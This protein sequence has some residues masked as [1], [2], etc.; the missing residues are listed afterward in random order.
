MWPLPPARTLLW[1][2]VL[3]AIVS[4]AFG[5]NLFAGL[6]GLGRQFGLDLNQFGMMGN[7]RQQQQQPQMQQMQQ[8]PLGQML[9][10]M[11]LGQLAQGLQQTING[12]AASFFAPPPA[13]Q[14]G[15]PPHV[16]RRVMRFCT[17]KPDHPK[18]RGHPEWV[19]RNG[20]LPPPAQAGG[21]DLSNLQDAFP[22]L[23]GNFQLPPVPMMA[24]QNV[25]ANVPDVLKAFVPA[26]IL[27]QITAF[28]KQALLKPEAL[29]QRA[30][31][32]EHEA[33]V[34]KV[35]SPHK[36][37]D[38]IDH[39]VE[40]RLAR[41]HQVKK[42]LLKKA[43]LDATVEPE[44][45]G[46]F[47]KDIL[48]TEGQANLLINEINSNRVAPAPPGA[49][50]ARGRARAA[51]RRHKRNAVFLEQNAAQMW[52]AGQPIPYMFDQS[53]SEVDKGAVHEAVRQIQTAVPCIRFQFV[54]S[55]P[56]TS[57]LYYTKIAS[58]TL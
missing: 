43:G 17:R 51:A 41:T 2:S 1:S 37:I 25:L 57:H 55:K 33:V 34:R 23:L 10:G 27:G 14:S 13:S 58:P 50:R 47:Q 38:Q 52:P 28:A 16:L 36:S 39:D 6:G 18:C 9:G 12:V 15:I 44:N 20:R 22:N 29:N 54:T 3:L 53:L 26:P 42:A 56:A 48:L 40:L 49:V 30:T 45:D 7:Q 35:L 5:Q 24:L 8:N 46:V 11:G 32:A 31:I 4:Y 19:I 21:L